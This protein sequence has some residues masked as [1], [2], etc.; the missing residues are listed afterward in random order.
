LIAFAAAAAAA[1]VLAIAV[2]ALLQSL[3]LQRA[4]ARLAAAKAGAAEAAGLRQEIDELTQ[5]AD[6]IAAERRRVARP[7]RVLA[8]MTGA[9]PDSA[10]IATFTLHEGRVAVTG[11]SPDA[12]QLIERFTASPLFGDPA[13]AGP[14][15][16]TAG[17]S[18]ES[19][20][21]GAALVESRAP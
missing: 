20:S 9:M 15:V 6:F 5:M 16:R 13:F 18:G 2:P 19:F 8:A 1:I 7:L 3:A 12:A 17:G 21:I 11:V 4:E 10:Y 14:I